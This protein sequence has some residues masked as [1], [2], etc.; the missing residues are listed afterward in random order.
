[1][2]VP[3]IVLLLCISSFAQKLPV[4]KGCVG[5]VQGFTSI[6]DDK[7]IRELVSD[8]DK[9]AI[10]AFIGDDKR[11]FRSAIAIDGQLAGITARKEVVAIAV[12]SGEHTVCIVGLDSGPVR[13]TGKP[14]LATLKIEA[15]RIYYYQ[16]ILN[17][18]VTGGDYMSVRD[19]GEDEFAVGA[20]LE[21]VQ[22]VRLGM[23]SEKR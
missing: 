19:F 22:K 23:E 5:V 3:A 17:E 12:N 7:P 4:P 20:A 9:Q 2:K 21:K 16:Q 1:M 11:L 6:R 10:I 8:P 14:Y 13:R 18:N 15:G